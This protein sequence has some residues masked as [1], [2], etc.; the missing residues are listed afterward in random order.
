MTCR[1]FT[2]LNRQASSKTIDT[3]RL[4][5]QLSEKHHKQTGI[6]ETKTVTDKLDSKGLVCLIKTV[7]LT[8]TTAPTKLT[9]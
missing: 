5:Y 1:N 3:S 6:Q 2:L 4:P 7:N 9:D 8:R